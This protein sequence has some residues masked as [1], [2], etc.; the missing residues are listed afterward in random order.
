M[1]TV[2]IHRK[3]ERPCIRLVQAVYVHPCVLKACAWGQGPVLQAK[4]LA[5]LHGGAQ[6]AAIRPAACDAVDK[7]EL[8]RPLHVVIRVAAAHGRIKKVPVPQARRRIERHTAGVDGGVFTCVVT[9]V[10]VIVANRDS[11]RAFLAQPVIQACQGTG[12]VEVI[13]GQGLQRL[14]LCELPA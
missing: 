5:E 11:G 9:E 4:L 12:T 3:V 7:T 1:G 10:R 13:V 14:E 2:T 6:L 8:H